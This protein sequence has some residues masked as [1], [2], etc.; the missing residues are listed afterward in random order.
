VALSPDSISEDKGPD[1][2]RCVD[3]FQEMVD[4]RFNWSVCLEQRSDVDSGK[5]PPLD[6]RLSHARLAD[7]GSE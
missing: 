3:F 1:G 2:D 4:T 5:I 7:L 6:S